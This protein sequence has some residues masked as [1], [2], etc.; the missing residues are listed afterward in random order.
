MTVNDFG[1][2]QRDTDVKRDVRQNGR[3]TLLPFFRDLAVRFLMKFLSV[4]FRIIERNG[5]GIG[6]DRKEF[7]KNREAVFQRKDSLKNEPLF[8]RVCHRFLRQTV[9]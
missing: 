9:L 8:C 4:N 2:K 1:T 5:S 3:K 7:P 6:P